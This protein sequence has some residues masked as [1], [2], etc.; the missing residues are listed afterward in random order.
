MPVQ[1][2]A[3]KYVHLLL[4]LIGKILLFSFVLSVL[5]VL[6]LRYINPR[7][8]LTMLDRKLHALFTQNNNTAL[9][10]EW[11]KYEE[12]S[13][14][15]PLAIIAAE[16]QKFPYHFGFDFEAI[17]KAIKYNER[18]KAKKKG[19]LRGASTISQQVAK[20]VFLWQGRS[21]LRKALEAYFTLLIELIWNKKRIIEVYMNVAETGDMIFGVEAAAKR[22]FHKP[23]SQLTP[24][25]AAAIAVS[26]PN[27]R[28]YQ[29]GRP[30]PYMQQRIRWCVNMMEQLGDTS[31]LRKIEK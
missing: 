1:P 26:L 19:T 28:K 25:E 15:M 8:T 3:K 16:D 31:L 17:K 18:A 29:P 7:Y 20:N 30:G 13:P 2:T 21:Y 5:M 24:Y 6:L 14:Y 12:I 23:A 10:A 4:S 27:P 22:Y 11:K 9:R